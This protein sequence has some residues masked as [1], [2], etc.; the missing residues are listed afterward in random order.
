MC[1][2]LVAGGVLNPLDTD[3]HDKVEQA[4]E[5]AIALIDLSAATTSP[6]G[7]TRCITAIGCGVGSARYTHVSRIGR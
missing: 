7:A 5:R 3:Q 1:D 2:W 6:R 4:F